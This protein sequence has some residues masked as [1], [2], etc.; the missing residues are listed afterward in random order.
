MNLYRDEFVSVWLCVTDD[1]PHMVD[2]V[3]DETYQEMDKDK[4]NKIGLDEYLGEFRGRVC[5]E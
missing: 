1:V 2:I 4:D 5:M 3:V